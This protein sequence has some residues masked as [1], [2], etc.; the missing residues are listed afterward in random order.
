MTNGKRL[1]HML[2]NP[3]TYKNWKMPV[4]GQ[5]VVLPDKTAEIIDEV[6]VIKQQAYN[7]AY[8]AGLNQ[9]QNEINQLKQ[10]LENA[11]HTLVSPLEMVD[12]M[13]KQ[14]LSECVVLLSEQCL[15]AELTIDKEKIKKIIEAM[16]AALDEKTLSTKV[17]LNEYDL[18]TIQALATEKQTS[19]LIQFELDTQLNIGEVR[20]ETPHCSI[21]GTVRNRMRNICNDILLQPETPSS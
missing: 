10:N 1:N 20:V 3:D 6:K 17:F 16:I 12:E 7:E 4:V 13:M 5:A 11:I 18:Q 21:D 8:Q 15:Q 14:T 19:D 9:A 2:S